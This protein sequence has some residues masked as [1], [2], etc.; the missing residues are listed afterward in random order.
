[1]PRTSLSTLHE[2]LIK[3]SQKS[4]RKDII[5]TLYRWA[6][7]VREVKKLAQGHPVGKGQSQ[8]LN[9]G[10]WTFHSTA[11]DSNRGSLSPVPPLI[12]T[13]R[14]A[15]GQRQSGS[16]PWTWSL[17]ASVLVHEGTRWPLMSPLTF[18]YLS[19][20]GWV[21]GLPAYMTFLHKKPYSHCGFGPGAGCERLEEKY[22][23][24]AEAPASTGTDSC[25]GCV[26]GV[27]KQEEC[28]FPGF[29]PSQAPTQ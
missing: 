29:L 26:M 10:R 24:C 5:T 7:W 19:E 1:M 20:V 13:G 23:A 2:Y 22:P 21:T 6:N 25:P 8:D 16:C 14:G 4:C 15:Q 9:L 27:G 17:W 12:P 3:V 18:A 28:D 11:L